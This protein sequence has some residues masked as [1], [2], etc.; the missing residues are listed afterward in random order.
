MEVTQVLATV[1]KTSKL[2]YFHFNKAINTLNTLGKAHCTFKQ[3]P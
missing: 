2:H 1:Y 3:K